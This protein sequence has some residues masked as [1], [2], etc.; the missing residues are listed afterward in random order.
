M[1]VR[2]HSVVLSMWQL[3]Q[4]FGTLYSSVF[5]GEINSKVWL[6]TL[7]SARVCSILGMWQET[8]SLP[9]LSAL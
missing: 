7:V 4:G 5:E 8:H 9:A 2:A 1:A 3:V 6:R